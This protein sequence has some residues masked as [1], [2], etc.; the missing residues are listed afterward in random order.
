[1]AWNIKCT[2]LDCTQQSS[3]SNIVDLIANHRDDGGWFLCPCGKHG[4]IEK[5]FP[6]Q[7]VDEVCAASSRSVSRATHISLLFFLSVM[8]RVARSLTS[9]FHT[10]KTF[11][12]P[13]GD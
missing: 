8:S 4:Y 1:M 7:E 3:A 2:D 11:V 9:G 6:L 13:G 12:V 10:T 5:R